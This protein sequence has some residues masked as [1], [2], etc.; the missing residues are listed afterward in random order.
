VSDGAETD[1]IIDPAL[2]KFGTARQGECLDAVNLHRG[3][4]AAARAMGVRNGAIDGAIAALRRKAAMHGFEQDP[5]R[6][7]TRIEDPYI[8]KGKSTYFDRDHKPTQE[9]IKTRLDGEAY[10]RAIEE[11]VRAFTDDVMPVTVGDAP[12][13]DYDADVIPWINIG[14]A[15]LGMLA[16]AAE[17]GENF[18]LRIAEREMCAAISMLIDEL[19]A[20]ERLVLND[21]GEFTHYEN[22]TA[23]T[24]Q[25]G[26][27]LDYDSRFPKM[28]TVYS[29]IMRF[30]V[31]KALT[32]ARFVDVIVNQGN[33][34]RTNDIWMAELLRVAYAGTPRVNVLNNE[35]VFIAYRMGA[36]LV[37]VHHS[38]KCKPARLAQVMTVDFAKDWGETEY[39]YIDI[40]HIHHGMVM[41]EHPGVSIESF[42][43]LAAKD[44]WAH[45]GGYRSRQSIT[46]VL[47]SRSY[48]E[49]GRRV[50]P[51]RQIRDRIMA[52]ASGG[53][54]V[55]PAAKIAYAV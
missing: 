31:D 2:K 24:E 37:M 42:N 35:S 23:T 54:I 3:Q 48:G 18:D 47:R 52:A 46:V 25:S 19:P 33:H 26:N 29:R 16:H 13:L 39:H 7:Q 28:I 45:D 10:L 5:R 12:S 1:W 55:T 44:R 53:G 4:R 17:T 22:F 38:D 21:L 49:V 9:W 43:V 14:D 27:V 36:T 34:S 11:A 20:C 41:K 15:H 51:I 30:M 8:I 50:L 6:V 40:G 32:K